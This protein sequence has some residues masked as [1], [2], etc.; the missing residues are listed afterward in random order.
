MPV[1]ATAT[2]YTA[3][4]SHFQPSAGGSAAAERR[5]PLTPGDCWGIEFEQ[6]C[7]GYRYYLFKN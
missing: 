5:R 3:V 6:L 1:A 2:A 4:P 7:T